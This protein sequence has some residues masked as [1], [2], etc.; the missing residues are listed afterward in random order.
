MPASLPPVALQI[1]FN[2]AP[3]WARRTLLALGAAATLTDELA[4]VLIDDTIPE[5]VDRK[6]VVGAIQLCDFVVARNSEW[7]LTR[8]VREW[9]IGMLSEDLDFWKSR[10]KRILAYARNKSRKEAGSSVPAYLLEP[11]GRAYHEV[12]NRPELALKLYAEAS[13]TAPKWSWLAGILADEQQRHGLIPEHAIEPAFLRGMALYRERNFSAASRSLLR[14]SESD[15]YR[16][17]VAIATHILGVLSF[18]RRDYSA[19][20]AFLERSIVI[21]DVLYRRRGQIMALN[22]RAEVYSAQGDL[23]RALGDLDRAQDLAKIAGESLLVAMIL[24]RQANIERQYSLWDEARQH[25][26]QALVVV[27]TRPEPELLSYLLTTRSRIRRD[28][29]DLEGAIDDLNAALKL[30]EKSGDSSSIA[31]SLHSRGWLHRDKGEFVSALEDFDQALKIAYRLKDIDQIVFFLNSR[32]LVRRDFGDLS[33][34]LEELSRLTEYETPNF[35]KAE[36]GDRRR[37]LRNI[38]RKID[39]LSSDADRRRTH[40]S[41]LLETGRQIL[42]LNQDPVRSIAIFEK[43]AKSTDE[44]TIRAECNFLLGVAFFRLRKLIEAIGYFR[45][46]IADGIENGELYSSLGYALHLISA[47]IE[48]TESLLRKSIDLQRHP[49]SLSWLGLALSTAGRHSEGISLARSAVEEFAHAAARRARPKE[50][51]SLMVNLAQT[52]INR[53][54]PGDIDE[55]IGILERAADLAGRGFTWPRKLLNQ[56]RLRMRR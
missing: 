41:F 56:L 46:A 44:P 52:L 31:R 10:N 18:R 21:N 20:L 23:D 25:I 5:G 47:P 7:H 42:R 15:A 55:A 34:A 28:Q 16:D 24:S 38:L 2:A 37:I 17:E 36:A 4:C 6:A 50:N 22:T 14:V 30:I 35:S 51:P 26:D 29:Y 12:T 32:G 33:G 11:V 9:L 19:A 13:H 27:T 3:L 54:E 43:L 1:F 49:R 39:T 45:R 40:D 48:E 8:D 53:G